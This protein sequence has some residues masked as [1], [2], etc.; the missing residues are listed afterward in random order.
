MGNAQTFLTYTTGSSTFRKF[1]PQI[2]LEP[3]FFDFRTGV[4][5]IFEYYSVRNPPMLQKESI[6]TEAF[7]DEGRLNRRILKRLTREDL[8]TLVEFEGFTCFLFLLYEIDASSARAKA[9][10][11]GLLFGRND[12]FVAS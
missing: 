4:L 11:T 2:R 5:P 12:R 6:W 3:A 10:C 9:G 8:R 1:G 7:L